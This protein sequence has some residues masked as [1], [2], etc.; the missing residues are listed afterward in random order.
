MVVNVV[1]VFSLDTLHTHIYKHRIKKKDYEEWTDNIGQTIKQGDDCS[2]KIY[3]RM[4]V[5][6]WIK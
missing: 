3:M 1:V 4:C 5:C 6:V 2:Q